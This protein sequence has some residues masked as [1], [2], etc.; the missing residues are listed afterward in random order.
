[1]DPTNRRELITAALGAA[2]LSALRGGASGGD[3]FDDDPDRV[4][5]LVPAA[6]RRV[7]STTAS[8][9]L[10]GPVTA[11][12][13]F[14]RHSLAST[15]G[16]PG[17]GTWAAISET[18]GLVAWLY[19]DLD[20]RAAAR[21]HYRVALAAAE[22]TG[23]PLLAAY[24]QASYGQ[25]A[26]AVGDGPPGLR[27]IA[28]A[29]KRAA[30]WPPIAEAWFDVLT[31]GALAE[32]G[33][34]TALALVDRAET[35]LSRTPGQEPVWPWV[36]R[37]DD[38]KLAAYRAVVA[39]RLLRAD[40]AEAAF[41]VAEQIPRA[42]KQAALASVRRARALA[43][44]DRVER[45]CALA[46]AA[47]D[48]ATALGSYAGVHAVARFRRELPPEAGALASALDDRLHAVY[49]QPVARAGDVGDPSCTDDI[50]S[51]RW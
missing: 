39:A 2:A 24:M 5:T 4:L 10:I 51:P 25:F 44:D 35:T 8:E 7:E 34:E 48:T 27:L 37:F 45:A 49:T 30:S 17:T 32:A 26:T 31:A 29:R 20:E 12:L 43:A 28:T 6:Y 1:M 47:L 42:P 33:D 9:R 41:A 15:S 46:V 14:L 23:Q 36:Y 38:V 18:A 40:I 16:P 11:H 22:H 3:P 19:T 21:R 13:R 50:E